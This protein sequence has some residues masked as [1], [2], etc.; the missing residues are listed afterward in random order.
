MDKYIQIITTVD[1]RPAAERIAKILIAKRLAACV[2]V[3]GPVK[4]IYRW[5]GKVETSREWLCV[6]K[7]RKSLYKKV[8]TAIKKNHPYEVPEIIVIPIAQGSKDYLKWIFSETAKDH[9]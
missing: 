6:I 5:K 3:G 9:E 7:T 2:Q 8:E 4:S 1:K